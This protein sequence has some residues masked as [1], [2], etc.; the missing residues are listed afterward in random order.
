MTDQEAI[1][2]ICQLLSDGLVGAGYT[3]DRVEWPNVDRDGQPQLFKGTEPW[4]R[5]TVQFT[6]GGQRTLAP[7][8]GRRFERRGTV[9]V[10][11]FVPAGKRGLVGAS[12]LSTVARDAY[13]GTTFGG[14]TFYRVARKTVG[15][16][17]PWYQENV[18]ADFEFEE[19]K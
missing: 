10:Q 1:D 8:G 14:V 3:G 12:E 2:A 15:Q 13:E 6:D 17:G 7:V 11:C 18:S 16:D 5:V 4:C 9:T 19:I